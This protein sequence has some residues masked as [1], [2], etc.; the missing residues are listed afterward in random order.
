M[1]FVQR[2]KRLSVLE[3]LEREARQFR[4]DEDLYPLRVPREPLDLRALVERVREG[5]ALDPLDLRQRALLSLTWTDGSTWEVW[6]IRLPSGLKLF[7]DSSADETRVLGSGGRHA[8]DETDRQFLRLLC[9]TAGERFGITMEG[10]APSRV[11][12]TI[13][14]RAFLTDLFVDLFEVTGA[15]DSVRAQLDPHH[16]PADGLD[17]RADVERWLAAAMG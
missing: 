7:C 13:A 5:A 6:I 12:T 9:E 10:G 17:F 1:M 2:Q 3:A 14:D 15:E 16:Q 8:N 11:R 4:T